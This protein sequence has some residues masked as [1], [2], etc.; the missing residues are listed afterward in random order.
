MLSNVLSF[1][2]YLYSLDEDTLDTLYFSFYDNTEYMG[3]HQE[4]VDFDWGVYD[5]IS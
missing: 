1:I 2:A 4:P 5:D 3:E